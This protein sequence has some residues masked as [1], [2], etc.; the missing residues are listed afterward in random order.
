V[1]SAL[2]LDDLATVQSVIQSPT[3]ATRTQINFVIY[4]PE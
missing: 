2:E 1:E 3:A 4:T